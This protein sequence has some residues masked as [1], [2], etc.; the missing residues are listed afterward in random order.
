MNTTALGVLERAYKEPFTLQSNFARA[1]AYQV[2]ELASRGLLT[3]SE[4]GGLYG[5]FWRVSPAGLALL[6]LIT[7]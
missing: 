3:S 5:N 2:A 7:Q 6:D 4:G 1:Y